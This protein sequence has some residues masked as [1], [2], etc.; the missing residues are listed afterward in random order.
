MRIRSDIWVSGFLR[1]CQ[2][3]D[4]LALVARKGDET[5]GAIFV[6]I[7]GASRS[8]ELYGP[9]PAGFEDAAIDRVFEA[10]CPP[11]TAEAD[12]DAYMRRQAEFDSDHWLVEV[13]HC[14][15]PEPLR[16]W[17]ATGLR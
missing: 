13:E 17:L 14:R 6:K 7:V 5:A 3:H 1:L 11:G 8:A 10:V 2:T 15:D 9:A 4:A 12:V 16:A